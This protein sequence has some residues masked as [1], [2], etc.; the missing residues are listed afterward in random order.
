VATD[1]VPIEF[2]SYFAEAGNYTRQETYQRVQSILQNDSMQVMR[3]IGMTEVL[4]HDRH[5]EQEEIRHF[6]G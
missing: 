4:T 2:L 5:F 6:V 3:Q 1:E